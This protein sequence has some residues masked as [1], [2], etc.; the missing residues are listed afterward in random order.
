M[1]DWSACRTLV[2]P[3]S[4]FS[5]LYPRQVPRP[6]LVVPARQTETRAKRTLDVARSIQPLGMGEGSV[7]L[8]APL[9]PGEGGSQG[10]ALRRSAAKLDLDL[11][12]CDVGQQ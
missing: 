11:F 8:P 2:G 12:H 7:F 1:I 6:R 10:S 9:P 5:T 3:F 4:T